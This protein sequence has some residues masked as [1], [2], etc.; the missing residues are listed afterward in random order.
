[1]TQQL[2]ADAVGVDISTIGKT[3]LG[4]TVPDYATLESIADILAVS[5]DVLVGRHPAPWA[6]EPGSLID[7][8]AER[9]LP[10][11]LGILLRRFHGMAEAAFG[12]ATSAQATADEAIRRLDEREDKSA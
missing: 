8:A 11:D 4:K 12:L 1:M 10:E 2:L 7:G 6:D 9:R 3:E 5:L